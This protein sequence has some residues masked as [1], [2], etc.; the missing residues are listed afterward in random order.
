MKQII[1]KCN[2][3]QNKNCS[4]FYIIMQKKIENKMEINYMV[5]YWELCFKV[6]TR[7]CNGNYIEI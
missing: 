6:I 1:V 4:K 3:N 7:N 5:T 2:G